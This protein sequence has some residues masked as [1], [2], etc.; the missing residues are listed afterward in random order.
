MKSVPQQVLKL[1][2]I[3]S[4]S[5]GRM[6]GQAVMNSQC[7]GAISWCPQQCPLLARSAAELWLS[8]LLPNDPNSPWLAGDRCPSCCVPREGTRNHARVSA[9]DREWVG[10]VMRLPKGHVAGMNFP[11]V[12]GQI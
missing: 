6:L 5:M 9:A 11:L 3:S 1:L 2:C 8:S 7:R 12:H 10:T 4:D